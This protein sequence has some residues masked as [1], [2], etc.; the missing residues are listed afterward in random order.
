M[1]IS[2]KLAATAPAA[3]DASASFIHLQSGEFSH[4][5][6]QAF[7]RFF[8]RHRVRVDSGVRG[9]PDAGKHR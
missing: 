3:V 9:Q 7:I 1:A 2:S 6:I 4:E 5:T 8:P